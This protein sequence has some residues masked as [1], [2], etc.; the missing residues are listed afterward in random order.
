MPRSGAILVSILDFRGR[1]GRK[2]FWTFQL[3]FLSLLLLAYLIDAQFFDPVIAADGLPKGLFLP[4][5]WLIG[6]VPSLAV[7]VRRYHDVGRSGWWV[8]LNMLP[9]A[10][11][12]FPMVWG[13]QRGDPGLNQFGLS[14]SDQVVGRLD[15]AWHQPVPHVGEQD[16]LSQLERLSRLRDDETLTSE[17][18]AIQKAR[19]LGAQERA[20]PP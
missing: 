3:A 15:Q 9:I 17:E 20:S 14:P 16:T 18:F 8:L 19:I 2:E 4:A 12:L 13:L 7:Q 1:S 11:I 6:L 10:G 5:V